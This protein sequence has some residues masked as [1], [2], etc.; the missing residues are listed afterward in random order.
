MQSAANT[1]VSSELLLRDVQN[2]LGKSLIADGVVISRTMG[3]GFS[4]KEGQ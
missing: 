4:L 2:K 1:S 3:L